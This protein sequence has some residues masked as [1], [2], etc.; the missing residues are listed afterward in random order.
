VIR[1]T[2]LRVWIAPV[3]DA[4]KDISEPI[5]HQKRRHLDSDEKNHPKMSFVVGEW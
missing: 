5:G 1:K 3:L 2:L 4:V